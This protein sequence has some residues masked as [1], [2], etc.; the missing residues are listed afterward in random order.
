MLA[1]K[2][3]HYIYMKSNHMK[4][5]Y[6]QLKW[7]RLTKLR[8]MSTQLRGIHRDSL[9][10]WQG[11]HVISK[12]RPVD[13]SGQ[14]PGVLVRTVVVASKVVRN[15][16]QNIKH[17]FLNL[18]T[19]FFADYHFYLLNYFFYCIENILFIHVW[20]NKITCGKWNMESAFLFLPGSEFTQSFFRKN[21]WTVV[22]AEKSGDPLLDSV[23]V[24]KPLY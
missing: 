17:F 2:W 10:I 20:S 23:T 5:I 14:A 1:L 4:K 21:T 24:K 15:L 8:K 13:E 11:R 3:T 6:T 7:N 16:L 9:K 18:S 19:H 22:G 12:L